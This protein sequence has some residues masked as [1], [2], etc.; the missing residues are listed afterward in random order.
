MSMSGLIAASIADDMDCITGFT[1]LEM[2]FGSEQV[3][4]RP[5][6]GHDY[7][8]AFAQGADAVEGGNHCG[9]DELGPIGDPFHRLPQRFRYLECNDVEL[10]FFHERD[11]S[12]GRIVVIVKSLL[13]CN[14]TLSR[15]VSSYYNVLL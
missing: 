3:P 12:S 10:F 9:S 6:V 13:L 7:S 11:L 8:C 14:T 4:V 2:M 5:L 1:F 15:L